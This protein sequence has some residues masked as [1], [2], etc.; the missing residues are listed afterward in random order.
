MFLHLIPESVYLSAGFS[1]ELSSLIV[2]GYLFSMLTEHTLHLFGFT[3]AHAGHTSHS[4]AKEREL[5]ERVPHT[6]MDSESA[7]YG[8]KV[9]LV[10]ANQPEHALPQTSSGTYSQANLVHSFLPRQ[11]PSNVNHNT[12]NNHVDNQAFTNAHDLNA[13]G[14]NHLAQVNMQQAAVQ[15]VSSEAGLTVGKHT[16]VSNMEQGN[17]QKDEKSFGARLM[18]PVVLNILVG[19]AFHNIFDGVAIA[20]AFSSC[21]G[22]YPL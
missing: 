21:N 4:S 17:A 5:L 3:H 15:I 16:S 2:G 10:S 20:S 8:D 1:W 22:E 14:S 6:H 13:I 7:S 11:H 12:Q 19:D 18:S 9:V